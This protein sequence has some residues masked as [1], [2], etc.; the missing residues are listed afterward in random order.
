[1]E[2]PISK[3]KLIKR[4]KRKIFRQFEYIIDGYNVVH[5]EPDGCD[6]YGVKYWVECKNGYSCRSWDINY[7]IIKSIRKYIK[8]ILNEGVKYN[9][10]IYH[11]DNNLYTQIIGNDKDSVLRNLDFKKSIN[12]TIL[13]GDKLVERI[14]T[15][16]KIESFIEKVMMDINEFDRLNKEQAMYELSIN[17]CKDN[18]D[19]FY[20]IPSYYTYLKPK[21]YIYNKF[22]KN[23]EYAP[24]SSIELFKSAIDCNEFI[25]KYKLF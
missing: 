22:V 15:I 1:M 21:P 13:T 20:T 19:T 18:D 16:N 23:L 4:I 25:N 7:A 5:E 9:G 8:T 17:G 6:E 11:L 3:S 24:K 2:K 14:D 10:I 12:I